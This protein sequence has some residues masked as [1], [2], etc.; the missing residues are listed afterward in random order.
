MAD[1]V[2]ETGLSE[3]RCAAAAVQNGLIAMT[4]CQLRGESTL[5]ILDFVPRPLTT[6]GKQG[7]G[8]IVTE[9]NAGRW[10]GIEM[11]APHRLNREGVDLNNCRHDLRPKL[12]QFD[13]RTT[14]EQCLQEVSPHDDFGMRA[15]AHR[16][17]HALYRPSGLPQ[18]SPA[19]PSPS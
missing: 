4:H 1:T 11:R 6:L 16:I 18:P 3:R 15:S 10:I 5:E 2:M 14:S 7:C 13:P 8:S 17:S 12:R 19:S 9:R